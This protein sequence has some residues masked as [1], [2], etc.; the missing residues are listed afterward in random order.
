MSKLH[1]EKIAQ[2]ITYL[3]EYDLDS[4]LIFSS[5]GSDSAVNLVTGLKTVG[6]TFF[7][8]TKEGHKYAIASIIDAQESENSGLF[9]EVIRYSNNVHEV[10]NQLMMRLNP[11][12]IALDYSQSDHLCDGLTRGKY[13][14]LSENLDESLVN[15]FTSS[16]KVLKKI[17]SIK[18]ESEIDRIKKAIDLTTDIYDDVFKRLKAGMTETQVAEMF[19][20]EMRSRGVTNGITNKLTYP[21]V[22]KERIAHREPGDA[23]IQKGDFLIIDFSVNY[24]GYVSDIARTAY[25]LKAGEVEAPEAMRRRFNSVYEAI[26]LVKENI[27]PGMQ[28]YQLDDLAR[29]HLLDNDMPEISHATGHQ[30]GRLV[31]DGG[32][33]LG[34]RWPRYGS[35]PYETIE[36]N[37]VFTI[38]PTILYS[39]G[40]YSILTE[41]NIVVKEKGGEFLSKRQENIVLIK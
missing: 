29:K 12:H 20:D 36:E 10:L 9:D 11:R 31:H 1:E 21:M 24:E 4:W 32:A 28:G 34:P 7:I 33:L 40:D 38:E 13:L 8:I 35:A 15:R 27:R 19:V 17:R 39:N 30:I 16:E 26:T 2:A 22:L 5:E 37:M 14:W 23:V 3:N 18:T 25:F 6:N 41:E